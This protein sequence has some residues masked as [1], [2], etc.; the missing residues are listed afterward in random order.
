M[1]DEKRG[2]EP[3]SRE[4]NEVK[5]KVGRPSKAELLGRERS[6]S[7]SSTKTMEEYLKRNREDE[8]SD[9][10]EGGA[11]PDEIH[12]RGKRD[13]RT[14]EKKDKSTEML[15][16]L[17]EEIKGMRKEQRELRG[18]NKKEREETRQELRRM[19][20]EIRERENKWGRERDQLKEEIKKSKEK[21]RVDGCE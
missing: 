2:K 8:K 15:E 16:R 10:A 4:N 6:M 21:N 5:N 18:E 9:I 19:R 13:E 20:E 11:D 12:K 17:I 7:T 14:P 1:E 3:V